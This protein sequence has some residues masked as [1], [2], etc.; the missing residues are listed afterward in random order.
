MKKLLIVLLAIAMT[1]A[2][3]AFTA[4]KKGNGKTSDSGE[5]ITSPDASDSGEVI[6]SP[7]ASDSGE[8]STPVEKTAYESP[9]LTTGEN[10]I[11]I[12][13]E[14][15]TVAYKLDDGDW[16]E[17]TTVSYSEVEGE[18]TVT[19]K[20]IEDEN[21][22]ESAA[23]SFTYETVKT[24][25]T[26]TSTGTDSFTVAFT[27]VSLAML[28]GE[29][30]EAC[31]TYEYT[32]VQPGTYTFKAL[33]GWDADSSTFYAGEDEK[34]F[35][36]LKAAE[37]KLVIEDATGATDS[38]L[39]EEWEV[40]KYD[41]SGNWVDTTASI[42]AGKTYDGND[43][44]I[45]EC[46]NNGTKFRYGKTY[47]ATEMYNVLSFDIKGDGVAKLELSIKDSNSG[48]YINYSLGTLPNAWMHYDIS[49]YDTNWKLYY[50]G[51]GYPLHDAI[52]SYGSM[53]G[54]RS[55]DEVIPFCDTLSFI[56]NGYIAGGP[57]AHIYFDEVSFN[58]AEAPETKQEMPLFALGSYYVPTT[59]TEG[60]PIL[61]L[62]MTSISTAQL[63]TNGLDENVTFDMNVA[64][65]GYKFTLTQKDVEQPLT[66]EGAFTENGKGVTL[67]KASGNNAQ[68]IDTS[69]RY[70]VAANLEMDFEEATAGKAYVNEYWKQEQYISAWKAVTGQMNCREKN[71]TK[72]VN[73][74]CANGTTGRFTYN[75]GTAIG[76]ANYFE[77][78]IG[79]YFNGAKPVRL[80]LYLLSTTG[81]KTYFYGGDGMFSEYP[82]TTAMEKQ[83]FYLDT[84]VNVQSIVFVIENKAGVDQYLYT[85]NYLLTYTFEE[86]EIPE[87]P[88]V[89]ETEV[90]KLDFE[91]G[92][93]SGNYVNEKWTQYMWNNSAYVATS[94]RMNSRENG[95][96]VVNMYGGWTTYK[97]IYNENGSSLG[98][99]NKLTVSAGNYY[100]E[101]L[102]LKLRLVLTDVDGN[103]VYLLGSKSGF[104]DFPYTGANTLVPQS[105]EFDEM[106]VRSIT[107]F[108]RYESGDN[109]LYIDDL[110]LL[111]DSL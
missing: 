104:T 45:F 71:G 103:E 18:H 46:W 64:I 34:S 75:E 16:T 1:T 43:C 101:N 77:I 109:Y 72:V 73:L 106:E 108:V 30:Y 111:N 96:K 8:Q 52:A 9:V 29:T 39:Q 84:A 17:G 97:F 21:G 14:S 68:F 89:P 15:A 91:D 94:A 48:I 66:I 28:N 98:K 53:F 54:V 92:A 86:P 95:S 25:L 57:N 80:Q 38:I 32:A 85:D 110:T 27:G 88:E 26:I 70:A 102:T 13:H 69:I 78:D 20:A 12:A 49:L 6:T 59:I 31:E 50:N 90:L 93:G 60:Y 99:A 55:E 4:C 19:A 56:L 42:A 76:L 11:A 40:K 22:L 10:G 82:V 36:V 63:S 79:N 41:N 65:E 87:E 47:E 7:D 61:T 83:R 44:A 67:E 58:Y 23:I 74:A 2:L 51:A 3:F 100:K 33:G 81:S 35:T 24:A 37:G 107:V 105:F 5:V 62:K